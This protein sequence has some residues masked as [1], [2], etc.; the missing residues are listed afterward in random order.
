M[1]KEMEN[2]NTD[3]EN[4]LDEQVI[5]KLRNLRKEIKA[6]YASYLQAMKMIEEPKISPLPTPAKSPF[7][8]PMF[9]RISVPAL[10]VMMIVGFSV[11]NSIETKNNSTFIPINEMS[12]ESAGDSL[13]MIETE[14]LPA[15]EETI[16][17]DEV[18]SATSAMMTKTSVSETNPANESMPTDLENITNNEFTTYSSSTDDKFASYDEAQMTSFVNFYGQNF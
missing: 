18:P 1:N 6:P 15:T 7:Y 12:T 16:V 9:F 17:S 8:I 3:E 4:V 2:M 14:S 5:S 11:K 10:V 13:A